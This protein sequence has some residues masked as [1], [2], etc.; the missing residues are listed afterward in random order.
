[1]A[2]RIPS[3]RHERRH[4]GSASRFADPP[5][6]RL[7]CIVYRLT[8]KWCPEEEAGFFS[9]HFYCY[10]TSLINLGTRKHLIQEDL[11]DLADK[12]ETERI[13]FAFDK[14]LEKSKD[15]VMQPQARDTGGNC[16]WLCVFVQGSVFKALRWTFGRLFFFAGFVKIF[17]DGL[18]ITGPELLRQLLLHLRDQESCK[19]SPLCPCLECER[20][21][22][23]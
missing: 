8:G 17:Y 12:D 14:N 10:M 15:P 4:T 6:S 7:S 22:A 23:V 18:Q 3:S 9:R 20:C 5:R 13:A 21:N 19:H 11:W 16:L 1:M 2:S